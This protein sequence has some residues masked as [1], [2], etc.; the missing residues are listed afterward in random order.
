MSAWPQY[1]MIAVYFI[2]F[3]STLYDYGKTEK[4]WQSVIVICV[5]ITLIWVLYSGGFWSPIG[6]AP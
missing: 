5:Y 1:T 3:A 6:F 4:P 2:S